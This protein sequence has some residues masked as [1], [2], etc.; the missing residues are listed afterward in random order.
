MA[1]VNTSWSQASENIYQALAALFHAV[2]SGK[3]AW[4]ELRK[5]GD[6]D[7]PVMIPNP[8]LDLIENWQE[9]YV[10]T[11]TEEAEKD[12]LSKVLNDTERDLIQNYTTLQVTEDEAKQYRELGVLTAKMLKAN[13]D[14]TVRITVP[15]EKANEA[16]RT[17]FNDH[18]DYSF[19][20]SAWEAMPGIPY[21]IPDPNLPF[22]FT[23]C[24]DDNEPNL[25][26]TLEQTERLLHD[27]RKMLNKNSITESGTLTSP[28]F[29]CLKPYTPKDEESATSK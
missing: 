16:R 17:H 27:Y 23:V 22:V 7:Y 9:L 15:I 13:S 3:N 28:V 2:D 26:W 25:L 29:D 19:F 18:F 11:R 12:L 10:T 21:Q 24:T 6:Q 14:S 5:N 8:D 1:K 4:L 20:V